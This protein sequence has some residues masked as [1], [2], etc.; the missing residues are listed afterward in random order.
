[1]ASADS[2]RRL[3][4][5][6][7][8]FGRSHA[9]NEAIIEA[10]TTGIL[11]CASL[12]VTGGAFDH[13]VELAHAHPALGVG[14][15]LCLVCGRSALKPT[16]IPNLV[17]DHYHFSSRPVWAGLRYFF[18][19]ELRWQLRHELEG[20][21]QKFRTTGLALDHLNGHLNLHLHP[22]VLSLIS[23]HAPAWKARHFRLTRDPFWLNAR[24]AGGAWAYRLSHALIFNLLSWRARPALRRAGLRHT[25]A[26]FG[27]LQNGRVTEDYVARLLPRLPLGDF[28]LYAHPSRDTA[29]HELEA[30]TSS[31]VKALVVQHGIRLV[32]YQDL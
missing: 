5:T 25:D 26:V 19:R 7:D 31:R 8:D 10:H 27:L 22:T 24:L 4:V 28:E 9:I 6:A 13:A 18:A 12:I 23:R 20:Q 11:T 29:R 3:V 15:H 21:V 2:P 32:R 30:L 16:Q 14:L 1:M 17:D